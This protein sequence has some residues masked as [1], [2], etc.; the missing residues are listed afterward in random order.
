MAGV[1]P[2]T[3]GNRT[4]TT[5]GTPGALIIKFSLS[6]A[7]YLIMAEILSAHQVLL[8]PRGVS[9]ILSRRARCFWQREVFVLVGQTDILCYSRLAYLRRKLPNSGVFCRLCTQQAQLNINHAS[10]AEA[11]KIYHPIKTGLKGKLLYAWCLP[12]SHQTGLIT[13]LSYSHGS[14]DQLATSRGLEPPTSSVTGWHS[15]LLNYEAI[16]KIDFSLNL[17]VYIIPKI[18]TKI[19]LFSKKFFKWRRDRESNSDQTFAQEGLAIPWDTI[20]P[21]RHMADA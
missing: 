12:T 8:Y 2:T 18:S 7:S 20:T 10:V 17:Y 1:E 3:S 4:R 13:W 16:Y 19:K 14:K 6:T 11:A 15:T 9:S 5:L 21:P